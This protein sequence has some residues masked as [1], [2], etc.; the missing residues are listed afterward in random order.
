M[1]LWRRWEKTGWAGNREGSRR[2]PW[3]TQ[4]VV[5]PCLR[6]H[7]KGLVRCLCWSLDLEDPRILGGTLTINLIY[8][9]VF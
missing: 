2:S 8:S 7:L 9:V 1:V 6:L 4:E 3:E 5:Q